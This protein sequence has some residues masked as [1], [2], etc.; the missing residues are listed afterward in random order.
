MATRFAYLI[1]VACVVAGT[2][3]AAPATTAFTYQGTLNAGGTPATGTFDLQF[4][5]FDDYAAGTQVG[6]TICVD[7][8]SVSRGLFSVS[9]DF[10]SVFDGT[11]LW[12]EVAVR[13]DST[14]G[15]CAGGDFTTLAPRQS[16]SAAP[17]AVRALANGRALDAADGSP[18]NVLIVD[19]NGRVGIGLANPDQLLTVAGNANKP[20]GGTWG[21]LSDRR[22]KE[23]I[24]PLTG[25]LETLL[26]LN[27]Y[28]YEYTDKAVADHRGLPGRQAGLLADEVERVFPDWVSMTDD[29]YRCVTERSTTALMVEA[30]RD[31]RAEKDRQLAEKDRKIDQL[32][33]MVCDLEARLARLEQLAAQDRSAAR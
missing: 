19:N 26:C 32:N 23:N 16:L 22:L 12:I 5:L 20:G 14:I 33:T 8:V 7:N 18:T 31:L 21:Q 2:A 4:K 29:G 3:H 13:A 1:G 17:Y 11:A 27:G 30:L 15:N 9:V 25:T 24:T 10:G 28:S 6:T